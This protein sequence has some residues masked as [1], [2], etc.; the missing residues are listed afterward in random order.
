MG[1]GKD[2]GLPWKLSEDL[3]H[4]RRTTENG[5]VI[6]GRKTWDSIPEKFRPL[7][8][9]KNIV[10]S[11]NP[12]LSPDCVITQSLE[13]A[14][15]ASEGPTYVIGGESLFREIIMIPDMLS[16]CNSIIMTR[17]S[18]P[19]E[20]DVFFPTQTSGTPNLFNF[21]LFPLT[22]VS[23]TFVDQGIPYD[24]AVYTNPSQQPIALPY[25]EHEEY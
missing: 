15:Q 13:E 16:R 7:K 14:L 12:N 24:F 8:N 4:F 23:K 6:M 18:K 3:K 20:C 11:S 25:P 21:D 5:T 17:I 22:Y 2:G 1:I 10:L 9:R 19:F